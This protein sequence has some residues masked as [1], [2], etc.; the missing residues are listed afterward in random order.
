[1]YLQTHRRNTGAVSHATFVG[2]DFTPSE[3]PDQLDYS[4]VGIGDSVMVH[5]RGG[6][7]V[8]TF[9]SSLS[10]FEF[11]DFPPLLSTRSSAADSQ[12]LTFEGSALTGDVFLLMTDALAEYIRD[13]AATDTRVWPAL[14]TI[15]SRD[16]QEVV[17]V[18]RAGDK[19]TNDDVTLVRACVVPTNDQVG[20]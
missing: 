18:L 5:L 17:D 11:T 16:F 8:A 20:S 3:T 6:R 10:D 19:M 2:L 12:I 15:G 1:M 4:G 7:A 13:R 9:P 14:S